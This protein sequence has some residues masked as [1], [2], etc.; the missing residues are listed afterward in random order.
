MRSHRIQDPNKIEKLNQKEAIEIFVWSFFG[1]C[2]LLFGSFTPNFVYMSAAATHKMY[3][4]AIV[5]PEQINEKI[6]KFKQWMKDRFGCVVAMKSPAHITLIPPFWFVHEHEDA[7]VNA[8]RSFINDSSSLQIELDGFS[9]FRKKVLFVRIKESV[10]L[11]E[12]KGE[13]E[14]YFTGK[15]GAIFKKDDRPFHPHITIA[16][17]DL[18]PFHFEQAWEHF[19]NMIFKETFNSNSISLLKLDPGAWTVAAESVSS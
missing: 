3:Y 18:K 2:D 19:S 11:A 12:L 1:S 7:L 15:F 10:S 8:V 6:Q 5:C 17:R 4:V 13:V 14:E 16:N 9:H